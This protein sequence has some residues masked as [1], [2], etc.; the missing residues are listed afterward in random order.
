M[1]PDAFAAPDR[2]RRPRATWWTLR[3]MGSTVDVGGHRLEVVTHHWTGDES[4]AVDGR[5]V[6]TARNLGWHADRTVPV[7]PHEVRIV[8]RWYPLLPVV[9]EVDGQPWVD[10][11]FPQL[12][13]LKALG[14]APVLALAI[15]FGTSITW[16]LWRLWALTVEG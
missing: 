7:G 10:D 13:W 9:L 15:L 16:D 11:L 5:V 4:Y 1:S 3:A 12:I 14:G 2:H 6:A 8:T